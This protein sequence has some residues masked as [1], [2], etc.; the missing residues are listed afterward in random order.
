MQ[1]HG[2]HLTHEV[3]LEDGKNISIDLQQ[4]KTQHGETCSVI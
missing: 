3:V 4:K 1:Q 2:H